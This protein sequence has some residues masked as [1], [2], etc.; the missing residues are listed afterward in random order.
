MLMLDTLAESQDRDIEHCEY[1]RRNEQ[2]QPA[3]IP[4]KTC[5]VSIL[6]GFM[7]INSI[8][9][10]SVQRVAVEGDWPGSRRSTQCSGYRLQDADTETN[11]FPAIR[12][13]YIKIGYLVE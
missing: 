5:L 8:N 9:S 2:K 3:C 4:W 7:S 12:G 13:E 11:A 6:T 10:S 1:S